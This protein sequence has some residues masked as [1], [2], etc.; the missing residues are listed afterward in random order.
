MLVFVGGGVGLGDDETIVEVE[1]FALADWLL[2]EEPEDFSDL[3][4]E[5]MG[6]AKN[7]N[8]PPEV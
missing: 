1:R 2:E 4:E 5:V 7:G 3:A 8:K 6:K